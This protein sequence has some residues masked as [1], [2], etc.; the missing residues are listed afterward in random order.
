MLDWFNTHIPENTPLFDKIWHSTER[1][2]LIM[3]TDYTRNI[4]LAERGGIY[5]DFNDLVCLAPI[6][7]VLQAHAGQYMGV[8]DN[9]SENNASNYF[10]YASKGNQEWLSIVKQCT[11]TMPYIYNLI[12]DDSTVQEAINYINS[13]IVPPSNTPLS[14]TPLSNTP[15]SN[16]PLSNTPLSNT[17]QIDNMKILKTLIYALEIGL[18]EPAKSELNKLAQLKNKKEASMFTVNL[19]NIIR[20]NAASIKIYIET[21]EFTENWRFAITDVNLNEIMFKTNLPIFCRENSLPIYLLPFNY[22]HR[23]H[24]LISFVG[25][26]GDATSYGHEKSKLSTNVLKNFF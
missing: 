16:T 4:I 15:L 2:D 11:A 23:Y 9:I 20:S 18:A 5:T 14:N 12:H 21:V 1:Q 10:M 22:L 24:C 8:T 13:V 25:H 6:E 19:N 26:L 17:P 7:P 3:K